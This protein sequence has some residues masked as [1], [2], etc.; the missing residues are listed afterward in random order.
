MNKNSLSV[1]FKL[2]N[3]RHETYAQMLAAGHPDAE[4][5]K[6]W[7]DADAADYKQ[8]GGRRHFKWEDC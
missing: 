2:A 8:R 5:F 6:K 1:I 4:Q 7:R 3:E